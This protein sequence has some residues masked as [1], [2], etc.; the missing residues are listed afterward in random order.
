MKVVLI[1]GATRNTGLAVAKR[2][3]SEG[4]GVAITSRDGDHAGKVAEALAQEYGVPV[5]GYEMQLTSVQSIQQVFDR[6]QQDFGQLDV[7]VANS[8]HLG[9]GYSL[10]D[11]TE[12]EFDAVA[13]VNIKGTFFCCQ[14]AARLMKDAGGSIVTIGSVQGT[15]GLHG[16][17]VY[18]MSKAALSMLVRYM[19]YELGQYH[20]RANN[21][22][23]GAVHS[24]RWDELSSE[25]IAARR[26]RYPVGREST[27][28]EIANAVWFL[29]SDQAASIT[30]TDLT[31]DSGLTACLLPYTKK[32]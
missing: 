32:E 18:G 22:V 16:R 3:A 7:F 23:A 13:D 20:I 10:L 17:A 12:A 8:A 2:F 31:V 6:V 29:A 28:E 25:E 11:S 5:R 27:E 26:S 4:Y 30:G 19:A 9:V 24:C 15:G 21:V 1:T 14:S